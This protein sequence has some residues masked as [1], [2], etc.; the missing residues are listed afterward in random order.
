MESIRE[1]LD[2]GRPFSTNAELMEQSRAATALAAAKDPDEAVVVADPVHAIAQYMHAISETLIRLLDAL[3]EP[4]VPSTG[5]H[6][7]RCIDAHQSFPLAEQVCHMCVLTKLDLSTV[8][9]NVMSPMLFQP[10]R[11]KS[12]GGPSQR[13]RLHCIIPARGPSTH[14]SRTIHI[15]R[16]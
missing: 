4:V 13:V 7:Q 10:G 9:Y 2:T 12:A 6:Y 5:P 15:P 8:R 14:T 3:P 1:C 11:S 16:S